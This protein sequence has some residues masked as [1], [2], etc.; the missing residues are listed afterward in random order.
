[1]HNVSPVKVSDKNKKWFECTF[2]TPQRTIRGVCFNPSDSDV[3]KFQDA[4][5]SKS[6]IKVPNARLGNKRPGYP[7]DIIIPNKARI[8]QID[9]LP[10]FQHQAMDTETK[11]SIG[12]LNNLKTGQL[13]SI[14]AY[15]NCL[16]SIKEVTQKSTKQQVSVREC[17]LTDSTGSVK[18]VLWGTFTSKVANGNTY[19]FTNIRIKSNDSKF[20]LSTTQAGC[21]IS[22]STPLTNIQPPNELPNSSITEHVKVD[23]LTRL[24]FYHVC[25][26]CK[27]KIVLPEQQK[28]VECDSCHITMNK[29]KCPKSFYAKLNVTNTKEIQ[30]NLVFFDD[31][32]RKLVDIYNN[33]NIEGKKITYNTANE[34]EIKEA[35]LELD[36]LKVTYDNLKV[37][38]VTL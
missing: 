22:P 20:H 10:G 12:N 18:L 11:C 38:D 5:T 32:V 26:S 2:Q 7:Q 28:L 29:N 30:F 16:T 1:M 21:I 9:P 37:T 25:L 4:A 34:T 17:M 8:E 36:E 3:K 13:I 6:P 24:S 31:T 27:K 15:V 33:I 14:T 23:Y 35:L 19:H